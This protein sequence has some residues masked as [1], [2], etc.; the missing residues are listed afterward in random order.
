MRQGKISTICTTNFDLLIECA[1]KREGMKPH[2]DYDLLYKSDQFTRI[3]ISL[4]KPV[5]VKIHGSIEDKKQ[6]AITLNEVARGDRYL[7]RE[8][9]IKDIFSTGPHEDVLVLG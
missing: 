6:M 3:R 5:V 4:Q 7:E 9:I 8:N 2:V 1:L